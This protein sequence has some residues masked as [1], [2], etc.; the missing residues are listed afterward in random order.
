MRT[1]GIA[2]W[3]VRQ[4]RPEAAG[5]H[6]GE[7]AGLPPHDV[8]I[9]RGLMPLTGVDPSGDAYFALREELEV[10]GDPDLPPLEV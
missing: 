2:V 5:R 10:W 8:A 6:L 1:A 4:G 9:R 7:A 3:L